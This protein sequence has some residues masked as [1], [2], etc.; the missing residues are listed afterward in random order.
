MILLIL[1]ASAY[2]KD[3]V[4]FSSPVKNNIIEDSLFT[5]LVY[6]TPWFTTNGLYL[7]SFTLSQVQQIELELLEMYSSTKKKTLVISEHYAHHNMLKISGVW[8]T[9][10]N[11]GLALKFSHLF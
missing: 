10:T 7:R 11:I 8:E 5:R 1:P 3:F 9:A 4:F 2:T 6:S